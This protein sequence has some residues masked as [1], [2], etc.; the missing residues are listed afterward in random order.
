MV[1]TI[2]RLRWLWVLA[3][4][5]AG[6]ALG[7][8]A[9]HVPLLPANQ[10]RA[11]WNLGSQPCNGGLANSYTRHPDEKQVRKSKRLE[12]PQ[13]GYA[14]RVPQIPEV[15]ETVVK[16]HLNDRSRGVVDHYFL[17]SDEDLAAPF[18]AI[19]ITE[20]PDEVIRDRKAF[21]A[22]RI[23][24]TGLARG[25]GLQPELDEITGPHGAALELL[26]ADRV[27]TDCFP[28]SE[29][30]LVPP[31]SAVHSLGISRFV[32]VDDRLIEF[33]AILKVE[34]AESRAGAEQRARAFMDAFWLVLEKLPAKP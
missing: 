26:V 27:G 28:T 18:A 5:L 22:V 11:V 7:D 23:L 17:I 19:V 31:S 9:A 12:V 16:L 6:S 21:E 33:S 24:Q 10:I 1:A 13:L 34:S 29:F 3:G 20:L 25:I 30:Q 2:S 4:A 32:V 8:P 14:F 15:A